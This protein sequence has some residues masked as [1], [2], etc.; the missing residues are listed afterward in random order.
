MSNNTPRDSQNDDGC[1]VF[2]SVP[3]VIFGQYTDALTLSYLFEWFIK[4]FVNVNIL[5][6]HFI[7]IITTIKFIVALVDPTS[8]ERF[9]IAYNKK[10]NGDDFI[11]TFK[12]Y[13]IRF[14]LI[15]ALV[16][17]YSWCIKHFLI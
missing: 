1:L 16:L 17:C 4:P 12:Y 5:I 14:M 9:K 2:L 3:I 7:G 15:P 11:M 6:P 10:Y 13:C 8:Y